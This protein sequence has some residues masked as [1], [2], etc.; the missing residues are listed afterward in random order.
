MV[1]LRASSAPPLAHR[2]ERAGG[3]APHA[4]CGRSTSAAPPW[5][6][7]ACFSLAMREPA[8]A[9]RGSRNS[10]KARTCRLT[11]RLIAWRRKRSSAR[12]AVAVGS[13]GGAWGRGRDDQPR[14]RIRCEPG[15]DPLLELVKREA[16]R[17][18]TR[19]RSAG[20]GRGSRCGACAAR[21]R[22][23]SP[24]QRLRKHSRPN[25]Y[26]TL[27][28]EAEGPPKRAFPWISCSDAVAREGRSL[29]LAGADR[30]SERVGG[31][32]EDDEALVRARP[33]QVGPA[34]RVRAVVG[35]VDV[36][37]VDR[38]PDRAGAPPM[39]PWFASVPSRLARPIVSV[40][41]PALA[42]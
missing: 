32:A 8:A 37:G 38:H 26:R 30:H 4:R 17:A 34:D 31:L 36:A 3:T 23:P 27:A 11:S 40:P 12:A 25:C 39:K 21:S 29:R 6:T 42:Q 13:A 33:V 24:H 41:L 9:I 16:G 15:R 14:R 7:Y 35:P 1:W 19:G 20:L 22:Q 18:R 5:P 10:S 28:L 2:S